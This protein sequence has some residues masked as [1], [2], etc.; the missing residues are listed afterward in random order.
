MCVILLEN[1]H[2]E[3]RCP[4]GFE[5]IESS[6]S[7][8]ADQLGSLYREREE[9]HR[10][11]GVSDASEIVNMVKSLEAQLCSIYEAQAASKSASPDPAE[12]IRNLR[13]Q[14]SDCGRPEI[15]YELIDGHRTL[16]AVWKAAA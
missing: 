13:D 3:R 15:V 2:L 12:E 9:L 8:L 11:I 5:S 10:E 16:R 4:M 6:D 14:F 1:Q 7:G